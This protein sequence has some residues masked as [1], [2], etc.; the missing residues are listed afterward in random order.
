MKLKNVKT[1]CKGINTA[2]LNDNTYLMEM[3]KMLTKIN[4]LYDVQI[5]IDKFQPNLY[6]L[7]LLPMFEHV[8][9]YLT[10]GCVYHTGVRA[11]Q[12]C[13]SFFSGWN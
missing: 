7:S 12:G 6:R 13:A 11:T 5:S 1:R 3:K 4:G 9:H 8:Y 10:G 2:Y